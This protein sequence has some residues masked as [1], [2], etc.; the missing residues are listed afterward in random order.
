MVVGVRAAG[1]G[2]AQQLELRVTVL[3]RLRVAV[4]QDGADLHAADAGLEVQL[5]AERLGDELL[6]RHMR[7]DTFGVDEDSVTADG[8]L[9]GDAVLVETVG[10]VLHLSDACLEIV[11]LRA[12]VEAHSQGVH[13]AATHAAVGDEAFV[14]DAEHLAAA[15]KL[16]GAEGYEAAHVHDRVLLR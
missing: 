2:Q 15:P 6:L 10:Q 7:E 13:V 14:H 4:G 8:A 3:A 11:E 9:V 12:L 5:H 1:D 16:L